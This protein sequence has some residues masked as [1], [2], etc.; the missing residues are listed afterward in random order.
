[1]TYHDNYDIGDDYN[2]DDYVVDDDDDD[3]NR[4]LLTGGCW[5]QRFKVD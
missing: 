2:Y 1:M 3:S 4:S 5:V